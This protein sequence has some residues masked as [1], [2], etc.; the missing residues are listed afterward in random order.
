MNEVEIRENSTPRENSF[1]HSQFIERRK[2]I[3]IPF[4][5]HRQL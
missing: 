5:I 3:S 4:H 1:E 2:L